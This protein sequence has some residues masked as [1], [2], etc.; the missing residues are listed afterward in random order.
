MEHVVS[1]TGK[2][3]VC[4][5]QIQIHLESHDHQCLTV[6]QEPNN[7][8]YN[9]LESVRIHLYKHLHECEGREEEDEDL[10]VV[11]DVK[12][13]DEWREVYEFI[14]ILCLV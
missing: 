13:P 11:L 9:D 10:K 4:D 14:P 1:H 3:E 5:C 7:C 2:H 12:C 6:E 8:R